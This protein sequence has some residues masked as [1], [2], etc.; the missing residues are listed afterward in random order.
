MGVQL[1]YFVG[2]VGGHYGDLIPPL[3]TTNRQGIRFFVFKKVV[4][5]KFLG[6]CKGLHRDTFRSRVLGV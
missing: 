3:P 1:L 2:T 4:C 5:D 6:T